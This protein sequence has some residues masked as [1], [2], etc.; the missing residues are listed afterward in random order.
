MAWDDRV[1]LGGFCDEITRNKNLEVQLS[2]AAALGLESVTPRFLDLGAGVRNVSQLTDEE[3]R[4]VARQVAGHGLKVGCV[5]SPLGKVRLLDVEDGTSNRFRPSA[6]YLAEEVGRVCRIAQLL[7]CRLVRGFSFYHPAG[8]DPVRHVDAAIERLKPIVRRCDD[9]GLTLGLEVEANLVGQNAGLLV[10]I[11]E[12]VDH[13]ALMLVFDGANLVT[14]GFRTDEVL[15]QWQR[16]LPWLGWLHVK[17]Y[18]PRA[19]SGATSERPE[20]GS[21]PDAARTRTDQQIDESALSD[22]VPAGEGASGYDQIFSG[23]KAALPAIRKRLEPRG[24]DRLLVD[25]EPHLAGGGQFGG[26]SGPDGFARAFAA[27]RALLDAAGVGYRLR[28]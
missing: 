20:R 24:I 7:D 5:G 11:A 28:G 3:A 8:S 13:P 17:D 9:A 10:S 4:E 14:Q 2:V 21:D 22:F 12:G 25:L 16:M 18:Q 6:D 1:L 23:L 19:D 15:V 26:F 27:L